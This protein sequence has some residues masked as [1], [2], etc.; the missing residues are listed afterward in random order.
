[1]KTAVI[2]GATGAI[3]SELLS[4]L[5]DSSEYVQVHCLVRRPL[6]FSHPKLIVHNINFDELMTLDL[7]Q[8]HPELTNIQFFCCLGT[9]LKQAGSIT[10]F[11]QIDQEYVLN[12]AKLAERISASTFTLISA[13][14]ANASSSNY[15]TQ[16]KGEVEQDIQQY[17]I[18]SIRIF[19]PSLLHGKRNQFRAGEYLGFLLLTVLSPFLQGKF[20]KYRAISTTQVA[21]ALFLTS[22]QD[23]DKL[24]IFESDDIQAF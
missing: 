16:T 23:H 8:L 3:G 15:Y 18:P 6:A 19:R 17:Q 13:I 22:I 20:K 12:T 5:L 14:G 2:V 24:V 9:T 21:K 1:M 11:K 4:L 7:L 10:A